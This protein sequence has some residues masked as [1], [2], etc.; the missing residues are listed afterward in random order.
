MKTN[1]IIISLLLAVSLLLPLNSSV[2]AAEI[3]LNTA[4]ESALE[5]NNT[6]QA[7]REK[8]KAAEMQKKSAET[9]MN[10]KLTGELSWQDE[11]LTEDGDIFTT[12]EYSKFLAESSGTEA[13]LDKADLKYYIAELEFNKK[14]EEVL[15]SVIK[16]Y[17]NLLKIEALVSN[18]KQAVKEAEAIYQDAEKRFADNLIT[19]A[20]LLRMEINLDK[21]KE[22]LQSI[23]SDR[24]KAN[25]QFSLVTGID[26]DQ[27]NLKDNNLINA[28]SDLYFKKNELLELA[29]QNR[30]DYQIQQLNSDLI[31]TDIQY[32]KAEDDPVFSLGGEYLFEDGR[33][34]TSLN[35]KYQFN[36]S[37]SADTRDQDEKYISLKDLQLLDE[38]EWKVTAALSYEFSDGGQN[39]ADVKAAEAGIKASEINL[40]NLESEIRIELSSLLRELELTE[41][42]LETAAKNLKRAELE[43]QSTKNRYQMGAVIESDLISAQRLLSDAKTDLTA[44]KY[45]VQLK[46]TEVLAAV[47]N[48]Y[49]SFTAGVLGGDSNE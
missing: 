30:T 5:N 26:T 7:A 48:I 9:I 11:E 46:K 28:Q 25:E 36:L 42:S 39:K 12:I 8:L 1:R 33:I 29:Y 43:Y 41:I 49:K 2:Y 23:E 44:A 34:K 35:S 19:E 32:L 40:D 31:K 13:Q 14:R 16:Q 27:L 37:G 22:K 10:S 21:N 6:L 15:E 47:E 18:Q 20:E 17:Y 24:I 4:L 3:G 38:S 45:A